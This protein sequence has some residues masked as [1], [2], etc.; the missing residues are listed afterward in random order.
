MQVELYSF[1][2]SREQAVKLHW[3]STVIK[4][5]QQYLILIVEEAGQKVQPRFSEFVSTS[6]RSG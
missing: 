3:S 4:S 1:S 6:Q 5:S 2:I